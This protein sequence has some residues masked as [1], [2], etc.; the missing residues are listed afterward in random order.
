MKWYILDLL[1]GVTGTVRAH[2]GLD[3]LQVIFNIIKNK[4]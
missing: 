3:P 2:L 4:I 1:V